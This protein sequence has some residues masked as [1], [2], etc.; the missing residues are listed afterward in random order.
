MLKDKTKQETEYK[1][2]AGKGQEEE[3]ELA[4]RLL[5]IF[6]QAFIKTELDTLANQRSNITLINEEDE[7]ND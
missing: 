7:S 2:Y 6:V 3:V 4:N 5:D 1:V